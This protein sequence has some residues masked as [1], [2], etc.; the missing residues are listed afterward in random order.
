MDTL[1]IANSSALAK[2]IV[3]QARNAGADVAEVSVDSGWQLSA[4]VRLGK[5]E[6]LEEAGTRSVALR[7]IR[8]QRVSVTTTSDLSATGIDRCVSDALLL[9]ELSEPDE[10]AGP[11]EVAHLCSPPHPDLHLYDDALAALTADDAIE[12]ARAAEQAALQ[13]DPRLKLSEG[14]TFS[15]SAGSS[16]LVLSSGFVGTVRG[17]RAWLEVN[18]VAEDTEGKRR[19]ASYFTAHRH[20]AE[21]E[22]ATDVGREAAR[23]T[24]AKLGARRLDTC[25]APVVFEPDAARSILDAFAECV[26]GGAIWRQAS[27]LVGREGDRVA[28]NLVTIVD[29]PVLAAGPHS[30]PFDGEGMLSRRNVVVDG[31]I[32]RTFLLDAYAARKLGRPPTG[33]ATRVGGSI[34]AATS[35]F[36]LAAGAR[37]QEDIVA[38]TPKGLYVTEMMGFGFNPLTGDF[39]RGASGFW[40]EDGELAFPV[41]EVTISSNLDSMFRAV[42]A[43]G[44][45]LRH[46][47]AVAAPTFR[48]GSMTIAG[49]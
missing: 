14:A 22:S 15:R 37:S 33:N 31:G 23:R 13:A 6:L 47:T 4:R 45:D 21:L 44:S 2:R 16:T 46:R 3:D 30:R 38:S 39:S 9:A 35:N 32:L 41:S 36:F 20:L 27:Y 10:L 26:L 7:V 48:V 8:D 17:T 5:T 24:L 25:E 19:Q 28:T 43:V 29:D 18:P 40:I 12:W 11:V 34:S 42:D 1:P 49:T